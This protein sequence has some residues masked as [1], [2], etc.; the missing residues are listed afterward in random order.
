MPATKRK[1]QARLTFEPT[2]VSTSPDQRMSPA[3][4]RYSNQPVMSSRSSPLKPVSLKRL[5][6]T[7]KTIGEATGMFIICCSLHFFFG[8]NFA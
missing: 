4:I 6:G 2:G 5:S 8:Y 1:R 7:Q 3:R